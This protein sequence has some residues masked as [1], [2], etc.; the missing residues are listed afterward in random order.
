MLWVENVMRLFVGPGGDGVMLLLALLTV[1]P[2]FAVCRVLVGLPFLLALV[3]F[4]TL[5]GA[6]ALVLAVAG[7]WPFT[8]VWPDA[9]ALLGLGLV[10]LFVRRWVL[11]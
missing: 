1:V 6:A 7:V 10:G 11:T 8:T 5:A 9:V 4:S 2:A 3:I